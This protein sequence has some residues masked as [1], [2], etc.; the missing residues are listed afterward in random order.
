MFE[1]VWLRHLGMLV[2]E[3]G[4]RLRPEEPTKTQTNRDPGTDH[5]RLLWIQW[6]CQLTAWTSD[7]EDN[8]R[9]RELRLKVY[10]LQQ[11]IY[12]FAEITLFDGDRVASSLQSPSSSWLNQWTLQITIWLA[13]TRPLPKN[14]KT[15]QEEE[16]QD[17]REQTNK[18]A[19]FNF[20]FASVRFGLCVLEII[21]CPFTTCAGGSIHSFWWPVHAGC[22]GLGCCL[23][24][25]P[26][27]RSS[28]RPVD[29][30]THAKLI[31][32]TIIIIVV[33]E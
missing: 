9:A 14:G 31:T 2:L 25:R 18:Q 17:R 10:Q 21:N 13:W 29:Q 15:E 22:L 28:E 16:V 8:N 1:C 4:N 3:L 5:I 33:V 23:I 30:W 27:D 20:H 26:T 24:N 19:N 11:F 7:G 32:I 12:S 6:R